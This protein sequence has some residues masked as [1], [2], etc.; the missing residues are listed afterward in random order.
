MIRQRLGLRD[1]PAGLGHFGAP[2]AGGRTHRG[3]DYRCAP[4]GEVLAPVRGVVTRL[5]YPYGDDLNW[6]YVEITGDD[7]L[8]GPERHRLFYVRPVCKEGD[9]VTLDTVIGVAQDISERYPDQG[10]LPQI[11][12][13]IKNA[14]GDYLK[15]I[16][17]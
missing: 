3:I 15:W 13:E 7:Q 6:R 2:R 10:M 16:E 1:D 4:G 5:G 12:Y 9:Q 14:A 8:N 11:H 17:P